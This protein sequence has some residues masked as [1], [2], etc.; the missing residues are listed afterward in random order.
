M[1]RP[2]WPPVTAGARYAVA[3]LFVLTFLT[4][5]ASYLLSA[6]AI[7]RAAATAAS[8]LQLCQLGNESRA[9]QITLWTRIIVISQPP[10]HETVA[11]RRQRLAVVRAFI[12]YV[13]RLFA[14]RDCQALKGQP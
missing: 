12:A 9:Q 10:P 2:H 14:P 4:S 6:S 5:G 11:Q 3:A 8:T 7:H 13:H 1:K